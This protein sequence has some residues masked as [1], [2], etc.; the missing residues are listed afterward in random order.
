VVALSIATF[1][2]FSDLK[3]VSGERIEPVSVVN[4]FTG[5]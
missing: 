3:Y 5:E 4:S 2:T 1:F